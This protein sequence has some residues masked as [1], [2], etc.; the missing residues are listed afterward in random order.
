MLQNVCHIQSRTQYF[1]QYNPLIRGHVPGNLPRLVRTAL[2]ATQNE[3]V[4]PIKSGTVDQF[5]KRLS[6]EV[7]A[8]DLVICLKLVNVAFRQLHFAPNVYCIQ[9]KNSCMLHP[10]KISTV[11]TH[12][13][14]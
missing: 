8:I 1:V 12:P 10:R 5:Y 6:A 13:Q 2:R 9:L 14:V 7:S 11:Y 3:A 4:T